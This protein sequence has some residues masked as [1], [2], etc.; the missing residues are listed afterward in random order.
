M[1]SLNEP[2]RRNHTTMRLRL[3]LDVE[4]DN[5]GAIALLHWLEIGWWK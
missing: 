1:P 2:C 5:P 3:L 4:L